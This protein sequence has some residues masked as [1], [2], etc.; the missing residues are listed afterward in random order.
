VKDVPGDTSEEDRTKR[1]LPRRADDHEI[2]P[3]LSSGKDDLRVRVAGTDPPLGV[4]PVRGQLIDGLT[5]DALER[6]S[7][8][9]R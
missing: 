3:R 9:V 7:R 5:H 8:G 4:P 1:T 2:G 6:G